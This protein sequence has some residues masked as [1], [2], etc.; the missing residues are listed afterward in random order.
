MALCASA[1]THP[2]P[3]RHVEYIDVKRLRLKYPAAL[4]VP[5][6]RTPESIN[7][8][9]QLVILGF[10]T[11]IVGVGF[12]ASPTTT[13]TFCSFGASALA[14]RMTIL[15][16][17][18]I[19]DRSTFGFNLCN[20]SKSKPVSSTNHLV[21]S[22]CL[23]VYHSSPSPPLARGVASP[24]VPA[25]AAPLLTRAFDDTLALNVVNARRPCIIRD[26][27]VITPVAC[28]ACVLCIRRDTNNARC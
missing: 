25:R 9:F 21:F 11:A 15:S 19:A 5:A 20:A 16:P 24:D 1:P 10:T 3:V 18:N 26:S 13:V 17:G 8:E 27:C 28:V 12:D 14:S 22:P 4:N 7:D 6:T 23:N 2:R